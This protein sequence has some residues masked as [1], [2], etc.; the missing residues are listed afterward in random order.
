MKKLK[1]SGI[2]T[3]LTF[4]LFYQNTLS[5]ELGISLGAMSNYSPEA[6][7]NSNYSFYPEISL[8]NNFFSQYLNWELAFGYLNDGLDPKEI[9]SG[10]ANY[11]S[12]DYI[13][14]SRLILNPSKIFNY[15][16]VPELIAGFS[17]HFL[18]S[19]FIY[20]PGPNVL[21]YIP[22][23][24]ET[25]IYCD[26]GAEYKITEI[27]GIAIAPRYMALIPLSNSDLLH[28][29]VRHSFVLLFKY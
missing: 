18:N 7:S 6:S 23:E 8:S 13:L 1:I 12:K 22:D 14:S 21:A 24:N 27:W 26:I 20:S 29:K 2:I 10:M 19:E 4:L 3:T 16:Y 28:N 17:I 11:N 5:Q 15:E 25:R 9:E